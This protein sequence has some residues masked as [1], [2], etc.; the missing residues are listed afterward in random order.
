VKARIKVKADKV[1]SLYQV[2]IVPPPASATE[3]KP[4][5][6]TLSNLQIASG[7][8]YFISGAFDPSQTLYTYTTGGKTTAVIESCTPSYDE[9]VVMVS[10]GSGAPFNYAEATESQKTFNLPAYG[11]EL[12][13]RFKVTV[14]GDESTA[15]VYRVVFTNPR[16]YIIWRGVVSF[17][18][19]ASGEY[20]VTGVEM[21]AGGN[22]YNA[23][24]SGE[25]NAWSATIDALYASADNPPGSFVARLTRT[26]VQTN[27]TE[28]STK[29]TSHR[30][31]LSAPQTVSPDEPIAL[32]CELPANNKAPALVVTTPHDLA[33]MDPTQ[34]YYLADD[35]DLTQL[36]GDWDGPNNYAGRFN[37]AGKTVKLV[38]SKGNNDTGMFDRLASGAVIENVN[39]EV[40]TKGD[41]IAVTNSI[42]FG[43]V[44][45]GIRAGGDYVIRNV[46]V[47]GELRYKSIS[48][49]CFLLAGGF[50]GQMFKDSNSGDVN[51]LIENCESDLDITADL[52]NTGGSSVVAI[53][54]ILG[55]FGDDSGSLII[56]NCRTGGSIKVSVYGTNY[57]VRAGGVIA[58]SEAGG[59]VN[60]GGAAILGSLLVENC[61]STT[62]IMAYRNNDTATTVSIAGGLAGFLNNQSAILRN[63]AALNERVTAAVKTGSAYNVGRVAGRVYPDIGQT[64]PGASLSNNYALAEMPVG[65]ALDANGDPVTATIAAYDAAANG[66]NGESVSQETVLTKNFWVDTLGFSEEVWDF[67]GLQ[68]GVYPR[69]KK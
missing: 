16:D 19:N 64:S 50:L 18:N 2:T 28:Q 66:L 58:T 9:A 60:G 42:F 17:E 1:E 39:I 61:Y 45:G 35:I 34:D 56:R 15:R 62:E 26:V 57:T 54:G 49:S 31:A 3:D 51:L 67:S 10:V 37:G 8:E 48:N 53:G 65:S 20:A 7:G 23:G 33:N 30:L 12:E 68:I 25:D 63:S 41:G 24:V 14:N 59:N 21:T 29:T 43:A 40:S 6:T 5:E 22:V 27:G 4:A 36:T 11:D 32:V 38:L 47:T 69:L 13:I 52:T 46:S 55:K 44:V